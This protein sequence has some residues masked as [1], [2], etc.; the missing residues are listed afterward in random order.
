VR[1]RSKEKADVCVLV[2]LLSMA[3]SGGNKVIR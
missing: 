3:V 1:L 2:G